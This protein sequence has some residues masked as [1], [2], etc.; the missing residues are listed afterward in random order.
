MNKYQGEEDWLGWLII[1][2]AGVVAGVMIGYLTWL[3][4]YS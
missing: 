4:F 2:I 3:V 1:A